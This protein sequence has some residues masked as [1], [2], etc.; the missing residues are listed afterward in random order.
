MTLTASPAAPTAGQPVTITATTRAVPPGAG[1]P[2]GTVTFLDGAT[3]LVTAQLNGAGQASIT[4]STLAAGPHTITA[5]YG[6]DGNF[7]GSSAV[8]QLNLTASYTFIGFGSPLGPAGNPA[9][10]TVYGPFNVNSNVTIKWQLKDANGNFISSLAMVNSLTALNSAGGVVVLYIPNQNTTGS[11]V[12]RYDTSGQQYVFNWDVTQTPA[13][14]YTLILALS[15]GR[16]W[17]VNV[18]TQ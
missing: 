1:L 5:N 16:L 18:V 4:T 8:V 6:G 15:D 9:P 10:A 7:S 3:I 14:Q 2:T 13:G 12:L 11:T 17:K